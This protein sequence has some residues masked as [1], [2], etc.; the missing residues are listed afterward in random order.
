MVIRS[1]LEKNQPQ[2]KKMRA[3]K[4]TVSMWARLINTTTYKQHD[5]VELTNKLLFMT[6]V[7]R[8]VN[9]IF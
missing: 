1:K 2:Q 3:T 6:A 7:E 5:N 4:R 8:K 9:H